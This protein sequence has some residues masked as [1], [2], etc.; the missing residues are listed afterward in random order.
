MS[1]LVK[2]DLG[3][4]F[5]FEQQEFTKKKTFEFARDN[6]FTG[7]NGK[8][9]VIEK[10]GAEGQWTKADVKKCPIVKSRT[11]PKNT[12]KFANKIAQAYFKE[13]G[14]K[15]EDYTGKKNDKGL[16]RKSDIVKWEKESTSGKVNSFT[17]GALVLV[18]G[19]NGNK[20][21]LGKVLKKFFGDKNY[22]S[23]SR[24]GKKQVE[25]SIEYLEIYNEIKSL[26]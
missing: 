18:D 20:K 7:K 17:P 5:Q 25:K 12:S 21:L 1:S 9:E 8:K 23:K 2:T 16:I 3:K 14:Y 15:E 13:Q 22:T 6:G 26:N 4:T 10:S 19:F 24:W 11:K